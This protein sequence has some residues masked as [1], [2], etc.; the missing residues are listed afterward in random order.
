MLFSIVMG[1][2]RMGLSVYMKHIFNQIN[3]GRVC[4]YVSIKTSSK[5]SLI[6]RVLINFVLQF[7]KQEYFVLVLNSFRATLSNVSIRNHINY[8][9]SCAINDTFLASHPV[10]NIERYTH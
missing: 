9:D 2:K 6:L 5:G 1:S 10:F 8:V 4:V 7:G 3:F